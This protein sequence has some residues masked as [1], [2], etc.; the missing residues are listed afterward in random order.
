V[1]NPR[2]FHSPTRVVVGALVTLLWAIPTHASDASLRWAFVTNFARYT[3][4]PTQKWPQP[5]TPLTICMVAGDR[6]MAQ[7]KANVE[8]LTLGGRSVKLLQVSR[9]IELETCAV[10][11]VPAEAR[12]ELKAFME[13]AQKAKALTVSDRADFIDEGGVIGLTAAGGRYTFDVNLA[14]ARSAELKL[15]SQLLKLARSVK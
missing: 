8:K 14:A 10:V 5:N 6:E 12:I 1:L 9:V 2:R 15:S 4:W 3:E 11:Y 13:A 7:E